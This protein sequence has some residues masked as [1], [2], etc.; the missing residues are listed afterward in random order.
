MPR[1]TSRTTGRG[2]SITTRAAAKKKKPIASGIHQRGK[3][4]KTSLSRSDI[5]TSTSKRWGAS[6]IKEKPHYPG[7]TK[8]AL[9][10][11]S[12]RN[13][14][15]YLHE[16]EYIGKKP[17]KRAK[18]RAPALKTEKEGWEYTLPKSPHH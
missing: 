9:K 14:Q 8:A 15:F 6:P 12:E 13:L 5:K 3:S 16:P 1:K 10:D 4:I 17:L 2:R 18:R 11:Q 7:P